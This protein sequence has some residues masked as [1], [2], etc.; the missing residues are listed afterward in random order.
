MAK[1]VPSGLV[2]V[3][4]ELV[5]GLRERYGSRLAMAK[6]FGSHSRGDASE[7]SDI[8][9]LVA[10]EALTN[11]ELYDVVAYA[12]TI[13]STY[14]V[15]LRPLAMSLAEYEALRKGERLLYVEIEKDGVAL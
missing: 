15:P 13:A 14:N 9:V 6:L 7:E 4:D 8:D 1:R 12:A 3:L 10:I 2:P 5:L 11:D